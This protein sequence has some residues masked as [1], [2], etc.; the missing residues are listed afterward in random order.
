[1][2]NGALIDRLCKEKKWFTQGTV[3]QYNKM[4]DK[5]EEGFSVTEIASM[6]CL[7]SD[8][9]D[10]NLIES[11]I[12]DEVYKEV[13]SE[14]KELGYLTNLSVY[15]ANIFNTKLCNKIRMSLVFEKDLN[16]TGRFLLVNDNDCIN[17]KSS[18]RE[19]DLV[20]FRLRGSTVDFDSVESDILE[21][22]RVMLN[23]AT[24]IRIGLEDVSS[25]MEVKV[26]G[27]EFSATREGYTGFVLGDT[28]DR[29]IKV[30]IIII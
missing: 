2:L 16:I 22:R 29:T 6:I 18:H 13:C 15:E 8:I 10:I 21:S 17:L 30:R 7:C 24:M 25:E 4:L 26:T 1:M 11:E 28:V 5:A 3:D 14:M 12:E 9:D 20:R 19:G 23:L 27:V